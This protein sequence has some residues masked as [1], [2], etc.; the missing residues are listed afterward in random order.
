MIRPYWFLFITILSR[1]GIAA[2]P[3]QA[4][5]TLRQA[6]A[7]TDRYAW[8]DALPL[9]VQA[10]QERT[11]AGDAA[12]AAFARVG[13]IRASVKEL[14]AERIYD[15]LSKEIKR[16]PWGSD[17]LLRLG[18]LFLKAD[19]EADVD[20]IGVRPF[21]ADQRR[22]DWQEI[23]VLSQKL[24]DRHIEARAKGELGLVKVLGGDPVGSDEIGAA[25]WQ[26]KDVGDVRNEFRFR[27][28]IARLYLMVGR[29]HDA[30]GHLER[31][32]DL[33]ESE[34]ALSYFPAWF[35]EAVAL[36]D[37]R[38]LADAL[39]FV[40]H[41]V[42]Q[43][44]ITGSPANAAQS[45]YLQ[46]RVGLENG[47]RFE[48]VDFLKHALDLASEAGYYRLI[49][50]VS[51]ELSRIYR[52]QG[53]LWKAVDNSEAG[54]RASREVGDPTD[55]FMQIHNEATL[56]ADQGRFTQADH[57]Y[58]GAVRALNL[59]LAKFTSAYARAY[60]VSRMSDLYS[61]YFS[62]ALL[63]LKDPSKAFAILEQARGRS[64]S[65][66][67][68]G[69][70]TDPAGE[71]DAAIRSPFEQ[72]LTRLQLRFWYKEQPKEFRKT[73][74]E[75]F[76]LGQRLGPSRESGRH[77]IEAQTFPPIPLA[78]VQKSLYPE[79]VIL[80]YVLR[81]PSSICLAISRTGVHGVPLAP[82][83]VIEEAVARYRR[84]ILQ[85]SRGAETARALYDL[86]LAPITGLD[87]R[88]RITIV[89]DGL[90]HLLPFESIIAPSGKMFIETHLI[91][92][93]PSATVTW[94]LRKI[95]ARRVSRWR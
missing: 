25:L 21:D 48:A 20:A 65:D 69:R 82:R 59:L 24:G 54:L 73:L 46:A 22:R 90:L 1:S 19:A 27:T 79:E 10:E 75:V 5:D 64:I 74:S 45:L 57:L 72:A 51:L 91:D 40:E 68:R 49:S 42:A 76:D 15:A 78:E 17:S 2:S 58:G 29:S 43:A 4:E 83:H 60:F 63:K 13:R 18:A 16:A 61:D 35:E 9:F 26:A 7:C 94:L 28:A 23:L 62:L 95:P 55:V 32:V 77:S 53:E 38:R 86:L 87:K 88:P 44:Q 84:E 33:A 41:C 50:I 70:W 52:A 89:P 6:V 71:T 11:E 31:A 36:L 81:E 67:L 14:S 34:Q 85:G 12:E 80:E 66:S 3:E 37:E 30:L 8:G 93:S 47:R 56:Q 39:P 92:Y